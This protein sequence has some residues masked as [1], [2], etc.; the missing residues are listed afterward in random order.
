[1]PCSARQDRKTDRVGVLLNH[2]LDD[3]LRRLVEPRVDDIH[4]GVAQRP[5]NDLGAAV[6]AVEARLRDDDAN[7][8]L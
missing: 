8:L 5:S 4:A 3:L 7:L 2:G 1:M 6:V